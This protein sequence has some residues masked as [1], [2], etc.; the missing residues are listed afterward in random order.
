MK[1]ALYSDLHNEHGHPFDPPAD[2][3]ADLVLLAGDIGAKT[4]GVEWA[5]RT[6]GQTFGDGR[7]LYV[8]GN[9]E[10][11]GAQLGLLDEM[12]RAGKKASVRVLNNDVATVGDVR[13][14]G[15]TLWT[16]F[17]LYGP[18]Q[19]MFARDCARRSINDFMSI[20]V[21]RR[22]SIGRDPMKSAGNLLDPHDAIGLHRTAR[23]FLERELAKPW[24]GKTVVVTHFAP[25]RG[26]IAPE[27]EG[28]VHTPYFVVD[29]APL[30]AKYRIDLWAFGH[31]HG[32]VDF[33][34]EGGCRVVSNQR[35]YPKDLSPGFRPDL[36][37]EV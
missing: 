24:E 11:Y 10:Y 25:H 9:H 1:I 30:M 12:R 2:L 19:V 27:Y 34:A 36:V 15:T 3:D 4:H 35:G 8:P 7:C 22:E 28:D 31:T 32:N 23:S 5:G 26:C 21:R 29:M 33:V 37:L 13:V 16:N 6:F 20:W 18:D 17:S 14:L